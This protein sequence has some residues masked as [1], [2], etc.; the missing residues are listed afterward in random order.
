MSTA[1]PRSCSCTGICN[2]PPAASLLTNHFAGSWPFAHIDSSSINLGV[3]VAAIDLMDG[4]IR[5]R[6]VQLVPAVAAG[7]VAVIVVAGVRK[8]WDR[9]L[10]AVGEVR[11]VCRK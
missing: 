1:T 8:V 6:N 7:A 5:G 4:H 9:I 10:K 3:I 2:T 11:E